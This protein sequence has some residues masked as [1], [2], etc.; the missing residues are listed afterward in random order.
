MREFLV[1]FAT[2]EVCKNQFARTWDNNFEAVQNLI[3]GTLSL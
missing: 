1:Q 2:Y 3:S